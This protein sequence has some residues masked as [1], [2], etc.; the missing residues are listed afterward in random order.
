[1]DPKGY[2]KILQKEIFAQ[3]VEKQDWY[4]AV[5]EWDFLHKEDS[6][7]GKCICGHDVKYDY[8]I[9]NKL[10]NE[11]THVG[12]CCIIKFMGYNKELVY[13]VKCTKADRQILPKCLHCGK[14]THNIDTNLHCKCEVPYAFAQRMKNYYNIVNLI[15]MDK[16]NKTEKE[17]VE[18]S[19]KKRVEK[20]Q[21][22]SD[23]QRAWLLRIMEKNR[24]V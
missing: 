19:V 3:S 16:L 13:R 8:W 24:K 14:R 21:K 18:I 15:N 4:K 10:N 23:K 22:L 9:E 5:E 2:F 17:F 6:A 7:D 1:M 11:V 20:D 12:S